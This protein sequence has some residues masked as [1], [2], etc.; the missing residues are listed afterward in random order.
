MKRCNK[1]T[2]PGN[3]ICLVLFHNLVFH[4][5]QDRVGLSPRLCPSLS[6]TW[7]GPKVGIATEKHQALKICI[8]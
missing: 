8:R 4:R 6:R 2:V 7:R 5:L 3:V 1:C